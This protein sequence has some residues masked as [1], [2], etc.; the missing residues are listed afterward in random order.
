MNGVYIR[1]WFVFSVSP[2]ATL[3][4]LSSQPTKSLSQ[5]Q[6]F[7]PTKLLYGKVFISP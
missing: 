6:R 7:I 4:V 2:V 1:V 3:T 5:L